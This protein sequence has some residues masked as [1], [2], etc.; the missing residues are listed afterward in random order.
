MA[1]LLFHWTF[2]ILFEHSSTYFHRAAHEIG[3]N[4]DP[5]ML[6]VEYVCMCPQKFKYK[7][8]SQNNQ[9]R[10][11]AFQQCFSCGLII[12]PGDNEE[13]SRWWHC[14]ADLELWTFDVAVR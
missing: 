5:L 9:Q 1:H 4:G 14:S 7:N 8:Q 12:G 10:N 3:I 13:Q 6:M 2:M 11:R